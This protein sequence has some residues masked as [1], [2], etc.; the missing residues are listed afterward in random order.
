MCGVD[1]LQSLRVHKL[2]RPELNVHTL[3][4]LC[5]KELVEKCIIILSLAFLAIL[6]LNATVQYYVASDR[7]IS[8]NSVKYA[9][10][11]FALR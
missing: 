7:N 1:V 4:I 9:F 5:P 11:I 6:L 8:L 3:K 10:R 2:Y